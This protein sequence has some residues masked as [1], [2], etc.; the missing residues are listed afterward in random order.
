METAPP[1]VI[2]VHRR[3]LRELPLDT[4]LEEGIGHGMA[5]AGQS[6][7]AEQSVRSGMNL[8]QHRHAVAFAQ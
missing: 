7:G 2:A 1:Q 4:I 5:G 8:H 3:A 6:S